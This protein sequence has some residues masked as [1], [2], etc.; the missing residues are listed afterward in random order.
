MDAV[1]HI[2]LKKRKTMN[3]YSAKFQRYFVLNHI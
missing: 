3:K 1:Y 2:I